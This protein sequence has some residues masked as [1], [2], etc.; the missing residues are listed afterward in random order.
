M[1]MILNKQEPHGLQEGGH[2]ILIAGMI[3]QD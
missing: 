2:N 1:K 3:I